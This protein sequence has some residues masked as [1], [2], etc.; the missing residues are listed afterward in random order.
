MKG[1]ATAEVSFVLAQPSISSSGLRKM[2][3]P[4][5]VSPDSRPSTAP[6]AIASA[7]G[8]SRTGRISSPARPLSQS[9]QAAYSSTTPTSTL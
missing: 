2:P 6:I 1:A 3:P 4:T 8:G 5:P 7:I 9:C